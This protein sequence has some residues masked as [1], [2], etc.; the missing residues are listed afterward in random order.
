LIPWIDA[1]VGSAMRQTSHGSGDGRADA[2]PM[3]SHGD[4]RVTLRTAPGS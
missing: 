4:A 2:L 3:K 1:V